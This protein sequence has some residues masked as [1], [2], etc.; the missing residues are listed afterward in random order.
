MA[1]LERFEIYTQTKLHRLL[2]GA[3]KPALKQ[4]AQKSIQSS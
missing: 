1:S 3:E 4:V 2:K